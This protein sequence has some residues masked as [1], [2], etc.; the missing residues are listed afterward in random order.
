MAK[1]IFHKS[2]RVF[3]KPVGSWAHIE[4]VVPKWIRGCDEPIKVLYDCGMGREFSPEELEE[5]ASA[6]QQMAEVDGKPADWRV[7]RG[8]NRWRTAEQCSHHPFPGTHPVIVTTDI[9]SGGWRVPGAEYDRDPHCIE[10]Q[11]QLLSRAPILL[12]LLKKFVS[13]A[14]KEPENLSDSMA[15][16]AQLSRR[17]LEQIDA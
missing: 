3:V 17:V 16:L 14:E 11:A 8:Q 10:K 7:I 1:A 6:L 5:E 13:N 9:E 4:A 15:E 2:Q 12:L